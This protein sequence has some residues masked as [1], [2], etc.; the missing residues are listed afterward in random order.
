VEPDDFEVR[1]PGELVGG[2][3]AHALAAWSTAHEFTLDYAVAEE[4]PAGE[5]VTLRVVARIRV[6]VTM[7]FEMLRTLND[8]LTQYERRFGEIRRPGSQS[9]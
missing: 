1:V 5:P 7:M 2:V 4:E 8:S 6:P 3:Y 9:T